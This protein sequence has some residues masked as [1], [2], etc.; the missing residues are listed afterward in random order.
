MLTD[1]TM[2]DNP[3]MISAPSPVSLP[4][5]ISTPNADSYGTALSIFAMMYWSSNVL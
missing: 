5:D 2:S 1:L 4:V 3:L